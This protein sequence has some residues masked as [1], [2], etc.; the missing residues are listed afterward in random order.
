MVMSGR[1][2]QVGL[3]ICLVGAVSY[4]MEKSES[5][6]NTERV[7]KPSISFKELLATYS[8]SKAGDE[9]GM[10]LIHHALLRCDDLTVE[11]LELLVNE[12]GVDIKATDKRGCQPIH[13]AANLG[14]L[15]L[16]KWFVAKGVR[17]G[18]VTDECENRSGLFSRRNRDYVHT[19]RETSGL[20]IIHIAS[21]QGHINVLEWL[22]TNGVSVDTG[23]VGSF[24]ME[25][26]SFRPI[27]FASDRGN[28]M[29]VRWLVEHGANVDASNEYGHQPI[30]RAAKNGHKEV[31]EWLV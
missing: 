15:D 10:Q 18:I 14:R 25:K 9:N 24:G 28:L 12:H 6:E 5:S 29:V 31:G 22:V 21:I 17:I 23:L 26:N 1:R 16:L 19:Y 7:V 4:S 20:Q 8:D 13:Y 3:I 30:H 2:I 27:H 11:D